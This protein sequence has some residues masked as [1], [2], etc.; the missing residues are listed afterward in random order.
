[1]ENEAKLATGISPTTQLCETKTSLNLCQ[2]LDDLIDGLINDSVSYCACAVE[3]LSDEFYGDRHIKCLVEIGLNVIYVS[4]SGDE[5]LFLTLRALISA[6]PYH[7]AS[8]YAPHPHFLYFLTTEQT[9][10]LI[11]RFFSHFVPFRLA[12]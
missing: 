1:M 3:Q 12:I 10:K 9:H 5:K 8:F 6:E 4:L 11:G 7:N 2:T